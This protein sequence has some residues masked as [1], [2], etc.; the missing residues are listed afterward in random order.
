[1]KKGKTEEEYNTIERERER[2]ERHRKEEKQ[3]K[4]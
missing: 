2:M 1:V 4:R 3:R